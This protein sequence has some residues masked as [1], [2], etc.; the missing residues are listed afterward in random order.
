MGAIGGC[1]DDV[2]A[3]DERE[4]TF[5]HPDTVPIDDPFTL[6]IGGLPTDTD[7]EVVATVEDGRGV[8]WS[9]SA[10]YDVTD[11]TID[12]DADVP[13]AGDYDV[14][15]TMRLI[16]HMEPATDSRAPYVPR[17]EERLSVEVAT[18]EAVVGSTTVTR[19]FGDPGVT[20]TEFDHERL[21]GEVFEPPGTEPAPAV[22]AL[23]GSRG[24]PATGMARLLASNGFVA[25]ALQYFGA[26]GLPSELVEVPVEFVDEA[27]SWLLEHERVAGSQV[28]LIGGSKGGELALLAGSQFDSIGAVVGIS[29]SGVAWEGVS[30]TDVSPGPSWTLEGEPVPYVPYADDPSV[31][32]RSPPFEFEPLYV[33]SFDAASDEEIDD[34]TIPVE[35]IDGPVLLVSGGA[36]RLWNAVELSAVAIDRLEAHGDDAEYDHLVFEDAG[37]AIQFPYVPTANRRVIRPYVL[38]GTPAGYAEADAEHWPR[39]L[40]T[41]RRRERS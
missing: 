20:A 37:H 19:P 13:I 12:L 27:A 34:A 28:G 9:A 15:D 10:T 2:T 8:S 33:A 38:G 24:E 41:L 1:V 32:D 23:H 21:V 17:P 29:A 26:D 31:R 5:D 36:D 7:V 18:D 6:E 3:D 25:L 11:G 4:P 35:E 14:A 22:V 39:A 30:M 16:Q 40:E